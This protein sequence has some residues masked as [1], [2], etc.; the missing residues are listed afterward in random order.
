MSRPVGRPTDRFSGTA[1][2]VGQWQ[3]HSPTRRDWHRP[4]CRCSAT[5]PQVDSFAPDWLVCSRRLTRLVASTSPLH[6]LRCTLQARIACTGFT[7]A[8]TYTAGS[9]Q[10]DAA[11]AE[12]GS[13][14]WIR[15]FELCRFY[16]ECAVAVGRNDGL[17][18]K[19]THILVPLLL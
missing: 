6:T 4:Y 10:R 3:N 11:V 15:I 5:L 2:S 12:S 17:S 8:P 19:V 1:M 16:P 18:W 9:R 7:S 14:L 13:H